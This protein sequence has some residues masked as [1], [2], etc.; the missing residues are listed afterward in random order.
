MC[1]CGV[2]FSVGVCWFCGGF[3]LIFCLNVV[4]GGSN[5]Y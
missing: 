2:G 3:L 4:I 5:G 1:Y